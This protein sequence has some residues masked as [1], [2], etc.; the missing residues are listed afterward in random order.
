MKLELLLRKLSDLLSF[1]IVD[2]EDGI[3]LKGS[4]MEVR[5][6]G[7]VL[8]IETQ[9]GLLEIEEDRIEDF[10]FFERTRHCTIRLKDGVMRIYSEE[11]K[12]KF[13][14]KIK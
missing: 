8:R 4:N 7:N 9:E 5:L 2:S 1:T 3:V 11:G 14:I 6:R 12:F 13:F 10:T